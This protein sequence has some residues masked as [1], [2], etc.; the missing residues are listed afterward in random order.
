VA[1][2]CREPLDYD[3]VLE[4]TPDAA[5]PFHLGSRHGVRLGTS[6]RL[7]RRPAPQKAVIRASTSG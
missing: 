4:S 1:L 2:V 6:T 5:E 3:V 7:S